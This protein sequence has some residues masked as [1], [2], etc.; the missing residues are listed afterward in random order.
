MTDDDGAHTER[1]GAPEHPYAV[2]CTHREGRPPR[3]T[4]YTKGEFMSCLSH[5]S[6]VPL[7]KGRPIRAADAPHTT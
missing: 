7:R 5:R 4:P 2:R 1:W 3:T 6:Q